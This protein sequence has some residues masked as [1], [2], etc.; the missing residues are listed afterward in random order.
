VQA[1]FIAIQFSQ[2]ALQSIEKLERG[3]DMLSLSFIVTKLQ[4]FVNY[5]FF[6]KSALT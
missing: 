5:C 2:T 3:F 1:L 4:E 6:F